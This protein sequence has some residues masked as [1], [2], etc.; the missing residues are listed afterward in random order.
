MI[1]SFKIEMDATEYTFKIVTD[2]QSDYFQILNQLNYLMTEELEQLKQP[3]ETYPTPAY[4]LLVTENDNIPIYN[5]YTMDKY[6]DFTCPACGEKFIIE[7]AACEHVCELPC[8][9]GH[10]YGLQVSAGMYNEATGIF[11]FTEPA[12]ETEEENEDETI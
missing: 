11:R 9:C 6:T 2:D 8:E 5:F 1:K 10:T 12:P 4:E 3:V 7:P